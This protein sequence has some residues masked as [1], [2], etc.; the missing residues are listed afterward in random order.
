MILF[1]MFIY[2]VVS[3]IV[4]WG[5][6]YHDHA[7]LREGFFSPIASVTI[8]AFSGVAFGFTPLLVHCIIYLF[9][10]FIYWLSTLDVGK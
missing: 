9:C 7:D 10:Y 2:A 5:D 3:P 6:Y 4:W 8:L 1:L